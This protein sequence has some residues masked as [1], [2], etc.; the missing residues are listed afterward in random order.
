MRAS[1][2]REASTVLLWVGV[3]ATVLAL[4]ITY[5]AVKAGHALAHLGPTPRDP[6]EVSFG[7]LRGDAA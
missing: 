3:V 7:V 2:C 1:R 4:G 6:F 5:A